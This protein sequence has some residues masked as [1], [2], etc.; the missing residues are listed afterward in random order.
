M[1]SSLLE[2][3]SEVTLYDLIWALLLVLTVVGIIVS[4]KKKISKWLNKWRINKNEEED[5]NKLV[6]DLKDSIE[7]LGK[8]VKQN[9]LNRDKELLQYRNDSKKIRDEMYRIMDGQAKDIKDLT[10]AVSEMRE[11]DSKT[12]RA[13]LKEKIE[14]IYRE[15]HPCMSCTSMQLEVL[16]ELIEEYEEHGGV[17]S[18]VHS[19][20]E[21]EMYNWEIVDNVIVDSLEGQLDT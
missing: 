12:R 11:K 4:Q 8:E 1:N 10:K 2:L 13:E 21:K 7:K 3:L 14:K 5:F 16:K 19:I 15:C 18:F 6:F 9:Q 20:V 17:N